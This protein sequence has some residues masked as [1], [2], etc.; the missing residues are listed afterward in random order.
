MIS[1]VTLS[2]ILVLAFGPVGDNTSVFF[3]PEAHA[4]P[5][6]FFAQPQYG[7]LMAASTRVI[8]SI[9]CCRILLNL[10]RAAL[11][12]ITLTDVST[13]LAFAA[14][15]IGQQTETI[16][17]DTYGTLGDEQ[18]QRGGMAEISSQDGHCPVG[19]AA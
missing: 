11:P 1:A 15:A 13:N 14:S 6:F 2:V 12:N 9:V 17:L 8:H 16:R 10:R 4:I 19:E 18:N 7:G 5:S 3:P